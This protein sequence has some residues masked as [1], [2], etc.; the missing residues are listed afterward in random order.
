MVRFAPVQQM[1]VKNRSTSV[2][3]MKPFPPTPFP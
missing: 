1:Q 3:I 2:A